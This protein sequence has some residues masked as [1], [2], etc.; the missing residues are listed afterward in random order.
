MLAEVKVQTLARLGQRQTLRPFLLT[1]KQASSSEGQ[2]TFGQTGH[3]VGKALVDRLA[4]RLA[5]MAM[6]TLGE[7][8][9]EVKAT[10]PV[11]TRGES[12]DT[13]QHTGLDKAPRD[14]S[15]DTDPGEVRRA[16][17]QTG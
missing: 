8:L 1:G 9:F 10:S 15:R 5:E 4:G 16:F 6:Q 14:T 7:T 13:W 12:Q 17:R 3:R 2:D 11:D